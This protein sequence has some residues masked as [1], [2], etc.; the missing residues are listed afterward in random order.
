[1]ADEHGGDASAPVIGRGARPAQRQAFADH[2]RRET[3][4]SVRGGEFR[5]HVAGAHRCVAVPTQRQTSSTVRNA[6]MSLNVQK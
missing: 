3:K 6:S 1:M 2:T 5:N 4:L